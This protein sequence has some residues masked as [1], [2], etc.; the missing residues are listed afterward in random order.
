M[1]C[2]LKSCIWVFTVRWEEGPPEGCSMY[3]DNAEIDMNELP[4]NSCQFFLTSVQM[5]IDSGTV[6]CVCLSQHMLLE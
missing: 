6:V 5:F 2:V 3:R 1:K 4:V